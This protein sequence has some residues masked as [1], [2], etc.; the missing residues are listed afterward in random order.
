MEPIYRGGTGC[1]GAPDLVTELI[2]RNEPRRFAY[3]PGVSK[4]ALLFEDRR[5]QPPAL[6]PTYQADL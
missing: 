3:V 1:S 4:R 2:E 5:L 6:S